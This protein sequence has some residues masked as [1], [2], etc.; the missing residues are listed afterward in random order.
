MKKE[1]TASKCDLRINKSG[2]VSKKCGFNCIF[3]FCWL[4]KMKLRGNKLP[5]VQ[6]KDAANKNLTNM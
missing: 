1:K 2:E 6:K 5:R 3:K 4:L